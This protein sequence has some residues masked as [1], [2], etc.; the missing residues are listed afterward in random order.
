M[1][2]HKYVSTTLLML[3]SER[4]RVVVSSTLEIEKHIKIEVLGP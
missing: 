1:V 3:L 4:V 2:R